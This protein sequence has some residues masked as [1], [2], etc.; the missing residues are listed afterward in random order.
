[1]KKT[2]IAAAVFLIIVLFPVD[3]LSQFYAG[4]GFNYAIPNGKLKEINAE[5]IGFNLQLE[6][7]KYC[8]WWYGLRIDYLSF[9]KV[10]DIDEITGYYENEV[11]IS[12]TIRFNI[13]PH[14]YDATGKSKLSN[15]FIPY[16]QGMFNISSIRGTDKANQLGFGAAL[17]GGVAYSFTLFNTC[18]L[19]DLNGLYSA[20]N[21]ITRTGS[22]PSLETILVSFSVSTCL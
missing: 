7:R 19:I 6:S 12:P 5:S 1:M 20:P 10:V 21:S 2:L 22:R 18:W 13:I 11:L 15:R 4:A 9:E 3:C 8:R 16:L 14:T 17:G